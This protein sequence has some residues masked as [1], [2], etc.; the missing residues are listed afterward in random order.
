MVA[1]KTA[2]AESSRTIRVAANTYERLALLAQEK[3]TTIGDVVARML[4]AEEDR[5]FFAEVDRAF[6]QLRADPRAW[7]D[8][9]AEAA[10]WES[11]D[12]DVDPEPW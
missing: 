1:T 6:K 12:S 3:D 7:S 9:E 8:Y 11:L 10:L 2:P 5:A 4:R